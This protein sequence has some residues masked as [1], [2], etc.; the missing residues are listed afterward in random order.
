MKKYGIVTEYDGLV[1]RIKGVDNIDYKFLR[2][3]VVQNDFNFR[4]N[5]HVEF[6][7]QIINK[8]DVVFYRANY[9]KVLKK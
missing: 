3:D 1:G 6:E 9:V 8:P 4:E 2:E 7:P 5:N